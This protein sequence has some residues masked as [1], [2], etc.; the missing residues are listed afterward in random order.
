MGNAGQGNAELHSATRAALPPR[1]AAPLRGTLRPRVLL[2][3]D[4]RE[5]VDLLIYCLRRAGMDVAVVLDA[6]RA[7]TQFDA[8]QPDLVLL[9]VTL[10]G[11][12][13]FGLLSTLRRRSEVPIVVLTA[14]HSEDDKVRGLELGADD[15]ITKPFSPIELVARIRA[16]L[17]L[18]GYGWP[19]PVRDPDHLEAGPLTLDA[20]EHTLTRDG[21]SVRLTQ[22][23]FRLLAVLMANPGSVLTADAIIGALWHSSNENS[24]AT[25]QVLVHRLR[26][27]LEDDP[28]HPTLLQTVAGVGLLLASAAIQ[29]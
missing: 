13:G 20:A 29:G 18:V 1:P 3:D 22:M 26:W 2:V 9:E 16:Q 15:Y 4:E 11:Y 28:A 19:T 5:V 14:L 6:S 17:R 24:R 25:L 23:E 21:R 10:G 27:K 7:L 12:E 8:L